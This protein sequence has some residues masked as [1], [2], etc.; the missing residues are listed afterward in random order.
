M[1]ATHSTSERLNQLLQGRNIVFYGDSLIRQVLL[2]LG[3]LWHSRN[4]EYINALEWKQ[5]PR[6]ARKKATCYHSYVKNC[7]PCGNHSESFEG[8][9][10]YLG[11]EKEHA[12]L[13]RS[14][15]VGHAATKTLTK[16]DVLVVEAGVLGTPQAQVETLT[17]KLWE[18]FRERNFNRDK[19][20]KIIHLVTFPP[21]FPT[22]GGGYDFRLLQEKLRLNQS[23][24]C[25]ATTQD[26][27]YLET[28]LFKTSAPPKGLTKNVTLMDFVSGTVWLQDTGSQGMNKVG[29]GRGLYGDC[30]HFCLPG[31][32]DADDFARA[33]ETML[34][35]VMT[36][37]VQEQ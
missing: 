34:L 35:Q 1:A 20:P 37:D 15:L 33:L 10:L 8:T 36:D 4:I 24:E 32:P 9:T 30:Q 23:L 7:I 11:Q 25:V 6:N 19:M 21:S 22:P 27:F 16:T 5:C 14:V 28:N 17:A 12:A 2:S 13:L 3:C 29:S 26:P 31:P 18:M